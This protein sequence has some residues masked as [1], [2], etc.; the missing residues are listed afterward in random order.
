MTSNFAGQ[1]SAIVPSPTTFVKSSIKRL[2]YADHT[3][4]Y[5]AHSLEAWMAS[6]FI[7]DWV[8]SAGLLKEGTKQY[9]HAIRMLKEKRTNGWKRDT[10]RLS[11]WIFTKKFHKLARTND[12]HCLSF[13]LDISYIENILRF[14]VMDII[15]Y[16]TL[17]SYYKYLYEALVGWL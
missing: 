12:C 15:L 10:K 8:V 17:P 14:V 1:L 11:C 2:S 5:W 4:G 9:E 6:F 3:C 16:W 7:P 13:K